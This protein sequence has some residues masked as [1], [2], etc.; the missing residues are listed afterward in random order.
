[1]MAS[2]E[3][4]A[5][6][7]VFRV[8]ISSTFSDFVE[9]RNALQR[10]VFP[11][12][13][14]LCEQ[15]GCKFQAVDL[16]WGVSEAAVQN[17]RTLDICLEEVLR[18]QKL[19]ERPNF[20]VLLGERYGWPPLPARILQTELDTLLSMMG[21][22]DDCA[23]VRHWYRLEEN[24]SPRQ[25]RLRPVAE[26][27]GEN[28]S[29][30][31]RTEPR[32]RAILQAAAHR[33]GISEADR[34]KYTASATEQEILLGALDRRV[35]RDQ[36]FCFFR[37]FDTPPTD[38]AYREED[39]EKR[40]QLVGLRTKLESRF[41]DHTRSYR[42][43]WTGHGPP[44][45]YLALLCQDVQQ[46][47][48][49]VIRAEV[50]RL[51]AFGE[52]EEE[53][54][55]QERFLDDRLRATA[56]AIRTEFRARLW[57][58]ILSNAG[59]P[60]MIEGDAG[61]GKTTVLAQLVGEARERF[62]SGAVI[63]RFCGLTPASSGTANLLRHLCVSIA[64]AYGSTLP[65]PESAAEAIDGLPRCLA[66]AHADRPLLL[67]L[68]AADHL[69][70]EGSR[71]LF[72]CL[73]MS[74]PAH[75]YLVLSADAAPTHVLAQARVEIP[76]LR[77]DEAA[78]LLE[79]WLREAGR[80]LQ[81]VQREAILSR[82]AANGSPLYLRLAFDDA[83]TWPAEAEPHA[84]G[85]TVD[86]MVGSLFK[87]LE[88][89][90]QHGGVL[91][92]LAM[93]LLSAA[94]HGLAEGEMIDLLASDDV[95]KDIEQRNPKGPA[96]RQLPFVIWSRFFAD[97]EPY[98]LHSQADGA[99]VFKIGNRRVKE[100]ARL[101][102]LAKPASAGIHRE[103]A[104]YFRRRADVQGDESWSG[105]DRRAFRELAY[106]YFE[107]ARASSD[108]SE[109][110]RLAGDER[111]QERQFLALRQLE[112]VLE[113][114]ELALQAAVEREDVANAIR[115][116]LGR[117]QLPVV[118]ARTF[119]YRLVALAQ[120]DPEFVALVAATISQAADRIMALLTIAWIC[121]DREDRLALTRKILRDIASR[122]RG[123]IDA[124][125]V[126]VFIG[127]IRALGDV[128]V[129]EALELLDLVPDCPLRRSYCEA[130]RGCAAPLGP[131]ADRLSRP[132]SRTVPE[133]EYETTCRIERFVK[134]QKDVGEYNRKPAAV[135]ER[136][137]REF[138]D[139]GVG[140]YYS[141]MAARYMATGYSFA[142]RQELSR[143]VF[144]TAASPTNL[145]RVH[146]GLAIAF[147]RLGD[148][149]LAK[150]NRNR[151]TT[152]L[153]TKL[154]FYRERESWNQVLPV[155]EELLPLH[156]E[157]L[158]TD[159]S[160]A[161]LQKRKRD[162][163][164]ATQERP[165]QIARMKLVRACASWDSG[166]R[167][168]AVALVEEAADCSPPEISFWIAAWYVSHAVGVEHVG[169][170]AISRLAD[171]EIQPG[172][173]LEKTVTDAR[174]RAVFQRLASGESLDLALVAS[175]LR[176]CGRL[177]QLLW[178]LQ[179]S[180]A[181]GRDRMAV[182]AVA[183]QLILLPETP[184]KSL[185]DVHRVTS[186]HSAISPV[187]QGLGCYYW[188][189]PWVFLLLAGGAAMA[190]ARTV[191]QTA[192]GIAL[193]FATASVAGGLA[194]LHLW[195]GMGI[196]R[197]PERSSREGA[198]GGSYIALWGALWLTWKDAFVLLA[199]DGA[200][201]G[202]FV[203]V[204]VAAGVAGTLWLSA[205]QF[206]F[207][208][209]FKQITVTAGLLGVAA[210]VALAPRILVLA[211]PSWLEG[212]FLAGASLVA[213]GLN[214]LIKHFPVKRFYE[215]EPRKRKETLVEIDL[216]NGEPEDSRLHRALV[217]AGQLLFSNRW[218]SAFDAYSRVIE[219][220]AF[221]NLSVHARSS[222]FNN[223]GMAARRLKKPLQAI[224]DLEKAGQLN[225]RSFSSIQNRA[226]IYAQ[227]LHRPEIAKELFEEAIIRNP[228][229]SDSYSSRGLVRSAVGDLCGAEQD[230]RM[231]IELNP[232]HT[233]ALWNLAGLYLKCDRFE[234]ACHL[235]GR[236]ADL[237]PEDPESRV[238]QFKTLYM[239]KRHQEL[240][241][242]M[243]QYPRPAAV[244]R[245][246][247]R[248]GG[249]SPNF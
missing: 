192:Q 138:G 53:Q 172:A 6:S 108:S 168:K 159:P 5:H 214:L 70:R 4:P 68:D 114:P 194:D 196:W 122:E 164:A 46:L 55:I 63:A 49:H 85:T 235:F 247:M 213:L 76:R 25:Y 130:W 112:P 36:V 184:R 158:L 226:L 187:A 20:V 29:W 7:R 62:P 207:T 208:P 228:S 160:L 91:V 206:G 13:R 90:A 30:R 180:A 198:E 144:T 139:R 14:Q 205:Y 212:I 175:A 52:F 219:D 153:S 73:P 215:R 58:H 217:A 155:L 202:F 222:A 242:L 21:N 115:F 127:I 190:L 148:R 45:E 51:V 39:P 19:T 197:V 56:G 93:G 239:M 71:D 44:P 37:H 249:V 113:C 200:G 183:A 162:L 106:H 103:L 224:Q 23:L 173:F 245:A 3:A 132:A 26:H 152:Y 128:G 227:E 98:L 191:S 204:T 110:N 243:R 134:H 69:E 195:K 79:E 82:A 120:E 145:V 216:P 182:D 123:P 171:L 107:S 131:M 142:V 201:Y 111:F 143:A 141:L 31:S 50:E 47:I 72:A 10:E 65:S 92:R 223:R 234:D 211:G 189:F 12:L 218:Q 54:I 38:S 231:A 193:I 176:I 129:D 140:A 241:R 246:Q 163:A 104:S 230:L 59:A 64:S 170:Q 35:T 225:P 87:R 147:Q 236:A 237:Q 244:F 240:E 66:L 151:A 157:L 17:H 124:F 105:N 86:E 137:F 146:T 24:D 48:E 165:G 125:Q 100:M 67:F 95:L 60:F 174:R 57:D 81:S 210:G 84:F 8:F 221:E 179:E 77:L 119:L 199:P 233:D 99:L 101:R 27:A 150:E 43:G 89:P 78:A 149:D 40:R 178:L 41:L 74:L 61:S 34:T 75:V 96:T 28:D 116:A 248:Q 121:S 167:D 18:C 232:F 161:S 188:S 33:A 220:S 133:A 9:E 109:L 181:H 42:V 11:K 154:R 177:P 80:T 126:D 32:L 135:E 15:K 136:A 97:I 94:R 117:S 156:N 229:D 118:I 209:E 238:Y 16:R 186:L 185:E 102:Y 169:E 203:T 88:D 166:A 2:R 83:R 1:M 22:P